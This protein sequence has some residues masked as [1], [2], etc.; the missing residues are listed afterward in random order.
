[1]R[2]TLALLPVLLFAV[3]FPALTRAAAPEAGTPPAAFA[4]GF[5]NDDALASATVQGLA[6]VD[7]AEP[8]KGAAAT[9]PR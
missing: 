7:R 3:L 4:E 8:Y 5:E 6:A 1:M 2:S 9:K